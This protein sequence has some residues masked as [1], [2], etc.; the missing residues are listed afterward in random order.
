MEVSREKRTDY[1]LVEEFKIQ[2]MTL[3]SSELTTFY[4][5]TCHDRLATPVERRPASPFQEC[6]GICSHC[7][8]YD[9]VSNPDINQFLNERNQMLEHD[10]NFVQRV[11]GHDED[12]TVTLIRDWLIP[13]D[14]TSQYQRDVSHGEKASFAW[15]K[16]GRKQEKRAYCTSA[17]SSESKSYLLSFYPL[18][19]SADRFKATPIDEPVDEPALSQPVYEF[20]TVDNKSDTVE[21][22]RARSTFG[23]FVTFLASMF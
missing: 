2:L 4:C 19:Y 10:P 20:L 21:A 8:R 17:I 14:Y 15:V 6:F 12:E 9:D 23:R 5:E 13:T 16:Y 7:D 1:A 22:T 18:C 11:G 3:D